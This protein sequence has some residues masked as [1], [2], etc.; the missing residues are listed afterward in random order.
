[1]RTHNSLAINFLN[2]SNFENASL[3]INY[4]NGEFCK[5]ELSVDPLNPEFNSAKELY[6]NA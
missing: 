2:E 1:M 6:F 4:P 3:V 5:Y